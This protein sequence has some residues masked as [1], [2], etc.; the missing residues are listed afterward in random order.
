MKLMNSFIDDLTHDINQKVTWSGRLVTKKTQTKNSLTLI[1]TKKK[2]MSFGHEHA[3][4][5]SN[6]YYSNCE[7]DSKYA[8]KIIDKKTPLRSVKIIQSINF[9]VYTNQFDKTKC[10]A[11]V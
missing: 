1:L 2:S 6:L 5:F 10:D 3:V 9:I 4:F 8:Y 7:Q 11:I